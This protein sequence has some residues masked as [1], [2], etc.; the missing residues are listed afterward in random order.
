M[1]K[2]K[3][4]KSERLEAYVKSFGSEIFSTDGKVLLCRICERPVSAEKKFLV[5]QHVNGARH[6]A[7]WDKKN[8]SNSASVVQLAP[9]IEASGKQSQFSLELCDAL[10]S[11][12]IPLHKLDNRKFGDFLTKWCRQA[13]P[14]SATLRLNYIKK[15]YDSKMEFIR[16][17]VGDRSIWVS[18]DETTDAK[19]RFVAHVVIGTLEAVESRCFLLHAECLAGTNGST[20]PQAFMNAMSVLWPAGIRHDKVLLFVSDAASYMK[21]AGAALKVLFPRLIHITCA[22]HA[23]HRM[24]E[25]V[26]SLFPSIDKLIS[27]V[28]KIFL[29]SAARVTTFREVAPDVP[30]PPQPS[31]IRWGT[32]INAALYYGKHFDAVSAAVHALDKEDAASI[33]TAH[34]LFEQ[35]GETLRANLAFIVANFGDLPGVIEKL[36]GRNLLLTKSTELFESTLR[37]LGSVPGRH[38]QKMHQKSKDVL[39]R[40]PDYLRIK[41]LA[42]ILS[43]TPPTTMST[44]LSPTEVAGF[45]FA[46]ITSTDVERTFSRLKTVLTDRRHRFTFENLKMVVVA[47]CNE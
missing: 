18:V 47:Y 38:R 6:K 17:S 25:L 20:I 34:D 9:F 32:W 11:A 45:K 13:I 36:E 43:G 31:L 24:S 12:D 8:Q 19:G 29:K 35:E 10:L 26:R 5:S 16:N 15:V 33:Q 22:A 28:K 1:P 37:K 41:E 7:S 27:C 2:V 46:P 30:L 4:T 3:S 21:T 23:L 14:C 44:E 39:S 40:N 42:K